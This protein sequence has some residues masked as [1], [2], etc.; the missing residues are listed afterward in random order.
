MDAELD[1]TGLLGA[2]RRCTLRPM[3]DDLQTCERCGKQVDFTAVGTC[4]CG[5]FYFPGGE[6]H[7]RGAI[8]RPA[9]IESIRTPGTLTLR[10]RWRN[11]GGPAALAAGA[12][13]AGIVL[14]VS[15][16]PSL[17]AFLASPL[18]YWGLAEWLNTTRIFVAAGQVR[19]R[20]GPLP[21]HRSVTLACADV[22]Q[23]YASAEIKR[24]PQDES[25]HD[26]SADKYYY[27][28]A[29]LAGPDRRRVK[30]VKSM[31]TPDLALFLEQELERE[32]GI[33][34]SPVAEE[35]RRA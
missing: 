7:P 31:S 35:L 33:A 10:W 13:F 6:V 26:G 1:R 25:G 23:L 30:L 24:G 3:S 27:L 18:W 12:L 21:T 22:V 8:A 11:R 34:D 29:I 5:A 19:V 20:T 17:A 14:A 15:R 28:T 9:A 4:P 32:L 16:S 2:H